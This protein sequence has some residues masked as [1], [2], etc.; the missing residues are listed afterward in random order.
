M[1]PELWRIWRA[2]ALAESRAL[3]LLPLGIRCQPLDLAA[4]V[5]DAR[6]LARRSAE[7]ARARRYRHKADA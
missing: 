5:D 6:Y 1:T 2:A 7:N 3:R 4:A